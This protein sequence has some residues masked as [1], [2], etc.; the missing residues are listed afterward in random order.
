MSAAPRLIVLVAYDKA[1]LLDLAGPLQSFATTNELCGEGEG[2]LP[3]RVR[4]VSLKGGPIVT[5]SG[6]PLLTNRVSVVARQSIDT[7]LCPGW[8][9][10]RGVV[11]DRALI[12]EVRSLAL[13]ARRV[14][15]VCT[16]AFLLAATGLLD[17]R[18]VVTHWK[19]CETLAKEYPQ[20]CVE[21]D[22]IF[23]R[24]GHIWTSAG[25]TAGIDLSLALIADD[26]GHAAAMAT[27]RHLVMFIKRPGGQAQFSVP[28]AA[29]AAEDTFANLHGWMRGNLTADLGVEALAQR[30]AMSPRHFARVYLAKVGRTPARMVEEMRI[31]AARRSLEETELSVKRIA[32]D[33]GFGD[34]ERMRRSFIRQ[35]GVAPSDYRSRFAAVT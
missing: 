16:G 2:H 10:M 11:I 29:Q 19:S 22:P 3:Y 33:C 20:L 18:R 13:R 15:S 4:V 25:I 35:L 28:L 5:S 26:L 6:L 12:R 9:T 24:D 8:P 30:A 31:E 27:A 14:A 7:V 34:E 1:Q 23:V 32:R 21:S 17:G